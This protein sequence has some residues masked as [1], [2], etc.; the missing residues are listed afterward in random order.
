LLY[1]QQGDLRRAIACIQIYVEF[2]QSV[3]HPD[4]E[5]DARWLAALYQRL[6]E[7]EAQE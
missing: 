5:H 6:H 4:A 3:N 2:A 7:T 1:E